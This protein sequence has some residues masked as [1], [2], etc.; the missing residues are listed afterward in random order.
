VLKRLLKAIVI[1]VAVGAAGVILL[2]GLLWAGRFREVTLPAPTGPFAVGRVLDAWT[3]EEHVDPFAGDPHTKR[4]LVVWIWYPSSDTHGARPADYLPAHWRS[5]M[6]RQRSSLV[7]RL[8]SRELARIHP[9]SVSDAP[10]AP[11]RP[12]YPVVILRAGRAALTTD[13]T[14]L[15]EDLASHGYVVV[16]FDAPYRTGLVV[17]PDGRVVTEAP[18]QNPETLTG[19]ALDR[20]VARLL[21][22]WTADVA[23]AVDRLEQVNASATGRFHGRLDLEKLGLV[24]HSLGGVTA[25]QFCLDDSRCRAG[26]D[27]D[28]AP[29]GAI[30]GEGLRQPFMFLLSDHSKE[31]DPVS[32]Q[33]L[34]DIQ[35]IYDRSAPGGRSLVAIRGA[36]HFTFSDHLLTKNPVLIGLLH[37]AGVLRLEPRRGLAVS[38]ECVRRFFDVHL[39][40]APAASLELPLAGYPELQAIP[41]SGPSPSSARSREP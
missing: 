10:L 39:E 9:H 35:S 40:V 13:Y 12:T 41:R 17:L 26:I 5:A 31:K 23:F 33:I 22:A 21:A 28:G 29:H 8:L 32:R 38:A 36:N 4:Q 19:D 14:T 18:G 11:A 25:A 7:G 37:G 24:G 16:G 27:L 34:A 2:L 20:V 30:V 15:A 3:D 1:L 6:D